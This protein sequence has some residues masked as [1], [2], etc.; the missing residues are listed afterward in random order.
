MTA[1]IV[2]V[3]GAWSGAWMWAPLEK[4]LEAR[5]LAY[6]SVDHPSVGPDALGKD[7]HD[8][9]RNVRG[10][11]EAIDG[12]VIL[13]GNSYG[14]AVISG[15]SPGV[16]NVK[17]LVY[18]AA[19]MP[20]PDEAILD[21]IAGATAPEFD[22]GITVDDGGLL[23]MDIDVEVRVALQ[24]SSPEMH[25]LVRA[26]AGEPMSFGTDPTAAKFDDVGWR[27]I[28]STY[29]VCTEDH[30]ILPDA[31]RRWAKER[32]TEVIEWPSDHCPQLS[33]PDLVAELLEK[34][35]RAI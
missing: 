29:V 28:P 5:G 17:R 32:S 27:T 13:V 15:A 8:D 12:P 30:S 1:T 7:V 2:L 10:I 35:A 22:A 20:N 16:A 26:H 19:M 3:P 25:D 18:L 31:Q 34:L 6:R 23:K 11:A 21:H 9:A 4:D 24:Q 14:G 33:H